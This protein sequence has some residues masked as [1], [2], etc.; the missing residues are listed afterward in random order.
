MSSE[1]F[2]DRMENL[3]SHPD[4]VSIDWEGGQLNAFTHP[5]ALFLGVGGDIYNDYEVDTDTF[6]L[7]RDLSPL[8][9][10][11]MLHLESGLN[12][13]LKITGSDRIMALNLMR[14]L[15]H[16]YALLVQACA[17]DED[18]PPNG[19]SCGPFYIKLEDIKLSSDTERRVSV[20]TR[21][22]MGGVKSELERMVEGGVNFDI[23]MEMLEIINDD[24]NI[25]LPFTAAKVF[26][27]RE[28]E[29]VYFRYPAMLN[30]DTMMGGVLGWV[31]LE[32]LLGGIIPNFK[33]NICEEIRQECLDMMSLRLDKCEE[34][35]YKTGDLLKD[36]MADEMRQMVKDIRKVYN[37]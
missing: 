29:G 10:G 15:D 7:N 12:V 1:L 25:M 14:I 17:M 27:R 16:T 22:L 3:L 36:G 28:T 24:L 33:F 11:I 30:F 5:E 32:R 21:G 13:Q 23:C 9:N 34:L 18:K 35:I 6:S 31:R 2:L 4:K 8:I 26:L 19:L 20:L 37:L